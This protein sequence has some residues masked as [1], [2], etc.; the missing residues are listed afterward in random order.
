[1]SAQD[2]K[3]RRLPLLNLPSE[4]AK[5]TLTLSTHHRVTDVRVVP[6]LIAKR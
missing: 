3:T 4:F 1:M 2:R 5:G 6:S